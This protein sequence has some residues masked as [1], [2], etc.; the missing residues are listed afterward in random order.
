M[1]L[2]CQGVILFLIRDDAVRGVL[3]EFARRD[4]WAVHGAAT[5]H[6][7]IRVFEEL[8][9]SVVLIVTDDAMNA[10]GVRRS[11]WIGVEFIKRC[12]GSVVGDTLPFIL[13]MYTSH[14]ALIDWADGFGGWTVSMPGRADVLLDLYRR[15]TVKTQNLASSHSG[16][17]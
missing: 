12:R 5:M 14:Q 13:L 10:G 16:E 1:L 15:L 2:Q 4:G 7:A 9:T 17:L 11:E 6:D 8:G 3:M